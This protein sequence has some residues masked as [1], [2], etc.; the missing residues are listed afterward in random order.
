M[1]LGEIELITCMKNVGMVGK[2]WSM[3]HMQLHNV[4]QHWWELDIECTFSRPFPT[5]T[6]YGTSCSLITQRCHGFHLMN[7]LNDVL[8]FL[9]AVACV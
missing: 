5:Y 9:I 4:M 8:S 7:A 1:R 2:Q 6:Y 3:I